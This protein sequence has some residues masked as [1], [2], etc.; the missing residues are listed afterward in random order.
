[1]LN[2][3]SYPYQLGIG[4][5]GYYCHIEGSTYFRRV[6]GNT[7]NVAIQPGA[8]LGIFAYN[9]V[10]PPANA[11]ETSTAVEAATAHTHTTTESPTPHMEA[12]TTKVKCKQSQLTQLV[13]PTSAAPA[14]EAPTVAMEISVNTEMTPCKPTQLFPDHAK[15]T[16]SSATT[17]TAKTWATDRKKANPTKRK[18]KAKHRKPFRIVVDPQTFSP[19]TP[20][21][22][23][24]APPHDTPTSTD[25]LV[26]SESNRSKS[27]RLKLNDMLVE[28]EAE[29]YKLMANDKVTKFLKNNPVRQ[30]DCK[31][32]HFTI[33]R[34]TC[35]FRHVWNTQFII[36][37]KIK[38]C[39]TKNLAYSTKKK[40]MK[41]LYMDHLLPL[42]KEINADWVG[43]DD[44]V[45]FQVNMMTGNSMK[46]NLHV[47]D[48]DISHQYG[49]G[50]GDYEGGFLRTNNCGDAR[51]ISIKRK[52][53]R[54]DGRFPHE[55]VPVTSGTRFSIYIYKMFDRRWTKSTPKI[56]PPQVIHTMDDH[57]GI[58]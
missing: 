39:Y 57:T 11:A 38:N 14:A 48:D 34:S 33:G 52:V 55:A 19:A 41:K 1:M 6:N 24:I 27:S 43:P 45:A 7:W 47:D 2:G 58:T 31:C 56:W 40:W 28:L 53:V 54:L 35:R 29:L 23:T 16:A 36:D 26:M 18:K 30:T 5:N 12:A 21:P 37:G 15:P 44:D 9:I 10:D 4:G 50:L 46:V 20:P 32:L 49:V 42:A 17:T 25:D 51:E 8:S 22:T 13:T 3:V